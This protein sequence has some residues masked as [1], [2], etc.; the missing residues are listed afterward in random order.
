[1]R[2]GIPKAEFKFSSS[3]SFKI[4]QGFGICGCF[5]RLCP[6]DVDKNRHIGDL[7]NIVADKHGVAYKTFWTK[8]VTLFGKYSV[9]GR[10]FVVHALSDDLGKGKGNQTQESLITGNA[11]A[12]LAC[13]VIGLAPRS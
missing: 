13:G 10:S 5:G 1:M 2:A 3:K 12:R 7:G 11:G 8:A 4:I 9:V 6:T